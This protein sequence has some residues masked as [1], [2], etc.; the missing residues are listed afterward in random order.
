MAEIYIEKLRKVFGRKTAVEDV[1]L[2]LADGIFLVILGPSGC[3]KTTTLNCVAGLERPTSG[4]IYFDDHDV[5]D[6]PPHVRNIAMVFQSSLLYPHLSA[7]KNIEM[8]LR[9]AR[10]TKGEKRKKIEEI[11]S[12]LGITDLLERKPFELSGGERQRVATAKAIVRNPNVFLLDEPLANLDAALRESLRAELVNIQKR[13]GTTTIFVTHDQTEAMTMGDQIAVMNQGK[14]LQVGSPLEVYNNPR[15]LFVAGFVGS[16]PMNFFKGHVERTEQGL[17][18][19]GSTYRVPISE[20]QMPQLTRSLIDKPLIM[21]IRPQ[22][23]E[24]STERVSNCPIQGKVYGVERLGE[25]TIV[26]IKT[27]QRLIKA[28]APSD[29]LIP[30]G[31]AVC[32]IPQLQKAYLFDKN[33]QENLT[34]INSKGEKYESP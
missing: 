22:D 19:V 29:F 16:P 1:T 32:V 11:S 8:S 18:F 17:E 7:R 34:L 6:L 33:T 13:L 4:R 26:I 14:V 10:L 20:K 2:R 25:R 28:I 5:T 30:L 24:V 15:N 21:G 23:T 3:G 27:E 12:L 31:D 9:F